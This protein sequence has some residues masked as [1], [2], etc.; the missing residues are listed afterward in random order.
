MKN[1]PELE[2]FNGLSGELTIDLTIPPQ[3]VGNLLNLEASA[4]ARVTKLKL[5]SKVFNRDTKHF[6][7][8][9]SQELDSIAFRRAEIR[10]RGASGEVVTHNAPNGRFF[11]VQQLLWA[12]EETERQTR[13]QTEW[14]GGVDVHH[15][16][17]EGIHPAKDGV[18]QICWGS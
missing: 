12:V 2:F 4:D 7:D 3:Q 16:F 14:L 15:V 1:H 18:W 6:R 8:L 17:F 13:D 10:L 9:T 11:T 5:E